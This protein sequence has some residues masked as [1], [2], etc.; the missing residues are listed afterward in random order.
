MIEYQ[1]SNICAF[2]IACKE[3]RKLTVRPTDR[4]LLQLY[5]LYKQATI[6]VNS[7]PQPWA[8]NVRGRAKWEAW[9]SYKDLYQEQ[10][11]DQYISVVKDLMTRLR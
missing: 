6:G 11:R 1:E 10:A 2:R 9:T 3:I 5:G 8:I 4:E 7:T